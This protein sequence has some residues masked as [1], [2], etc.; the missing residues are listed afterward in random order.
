MQWKPAL[1]AGME[2]L[3]YPLWPGADWLAL[4]RGL[5]LE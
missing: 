3:A 5:Q 4:D 1:S 2:R